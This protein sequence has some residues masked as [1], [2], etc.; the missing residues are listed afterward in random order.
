MF[1][2]RLIKNIGTDKDHFAY[3]RGSWMY[4]TGK[5]FPVRK[6]TSNTGETI[7][8][9][10]NEPVRFYNNFL[11]IQAGISIDVDDLFKSKKNEKSDSPAISDTAG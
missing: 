5:Y 4:Q 7:Y 9:R 3:L 2:F 8:Q 10:S 11:Q 6:R 1:S